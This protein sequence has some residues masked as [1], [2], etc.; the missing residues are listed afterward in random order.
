ME[1]SKLGELLSNAR[2][3]PVFWKYV[4]YAIMVVLVGLN[5]VIRPHHP[6]FPGE[7]LPGFWA[8]FAL[9]ATIAMVRI[10]KGAAHTFLGKKEGYYD[11]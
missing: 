2:Q 7:W 5:V 3:C 4:M 8:V 11:R 1:T 10:C 6:H 9:I